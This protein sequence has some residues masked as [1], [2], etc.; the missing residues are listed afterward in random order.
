MNHYEVLGVK[1][2]RIKQDNLLSEYGRYGH[3][4]PVDKIIRIDGTIKGEEEIKTDIHEV[5]HALFDISG[6]NRSLSHELEEVIC[7]NIE[8]VMFENF[9]IKHKK[10]KPKKKP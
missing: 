8:R 2:K 4:F 6:I 9:D 1:V 5:V 10:V 3:Y 7:H